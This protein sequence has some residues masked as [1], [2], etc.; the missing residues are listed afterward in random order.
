MVVAAEMFVNDYLPELAYFGGDQAVTDGSGLVDTELAI[1]PGGESLSESNLANA[2]GANVLGTGRA[3]NRKAP[4]EPVEPATQI[5]D[6][7]KMDFLNEESV[8]VSEVVVDAWQA[9]LPTEGTTNITIATPSDDL[10][11]DFESFDSSYVLKNTSVSL[12]NDHLISAGFTGAVLEP[13]DF[14]GFLY[15]TISV[16]DLYGLKVE[17]SLITNGV[18]QYSKVYVVTPEELAS[19]PEIYSVLKVRASE[20]LEVEVNETNEFGDRSFYMNDLRRQHVAFL[21]VK[22]GTSIYGF[23]Y[24]KDYHPQVA[25]LVHLMGG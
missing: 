7:E 23:A 3:V 13:E 11:A 15:K 6:L 4:V 16:G 21:T 17:K 2:I 12:T 5:L 19:A 24:P 20:G 18:K 25:N 8:V 1:V 9:P 10:F 22:I 14:D